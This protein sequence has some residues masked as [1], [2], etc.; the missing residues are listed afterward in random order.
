MVKVKAYIS[1]K[2][3]LYTYNYKQSYSI[4]VFVRKRVEKCDFLTDFLGEDFSEQ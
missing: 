2:I 3:G 4:T 1:Y